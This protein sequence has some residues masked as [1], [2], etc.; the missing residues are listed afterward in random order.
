MRSPVKVV[1]F[2]LVLA[3]QPSIAWAD[4]PFRDWTKLPPNTWTL[5]HKEGPDG[6]KEFA[7]A[8][9]AEDCDR[10]YL[11]G[12]GGKLR[13]RSTYERHELESFSLA[14]AEQ[15]W[16]EALPQAK[17][18]AWADG[19]WPPF[20]LNGIDGSDGPR[21]SL[22][23]GSMQPN[24]VR[25][26]ETENVHRPS[27]I[28]TFNQACYDST[29]KRI[30]YFGGGKTLALDPGTNTWTDLAPA[31]TPIGCNSLAWGSLCYDPVN[32]EILLFGGGMAFNLDG[33]ARTWL[34]SCKKNE[35]YRPKIE[36]DEPGLRCTSAMVFEP[37]TQSMVL[38]GGNDQAA[39]LNDTWV[40]H[41][42]ER[43]WERRQPALSPPPMFVVAAATLP[44]GR[45]LICG[46]NALVGKDSDQASWAAKET[47]TYDS[48]KNAWQPIGVLK[49]PGR[50]L[51]A[52][53]STKHGVAFLVSFDP[54]ARQTFALRYDSTTVDATM[55]QTLKGAAPGT[56]RF[57]YLEQHESLASA[58]KPD[59]AAH[60]KFLANLP[61]NQFV[62]AKPPGTLVAKTWSGAVIDTARSEVIYTGGGHSGYSGNDIAIYSIAENRWSL[63]SPPRFPPFLESTG[64]AVY[65][66]SYNVRPW[67]QH[68]YLWYG[69]D[70]VSKKVIYCARP[71]IRDGETVQ[72]DPDPGK[73]FVYDS[74]KH[75]HWTWVFD[76]ATR[77]L[78]LPSFGRPFRNSWDLCLAATPRGIY[79]CT[80]DNLHQAAVQGAQ[81][82]WQSLGGALPRSRSTKYNYEW[83]PVVHDSKRDRLIHLMGGPD[84]IEVHT[85]G[86]AD[87]EWKE[88]KVAGSA[89]AGRELAYL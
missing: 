28:H 12:A 68:T 83:L 49:L 45:V 39:A 10:I 46:S 35:W 77:K 21:M 70:P 79:A 16:V 6:G 44:G 43:R 72:L 55:A 38:F 13:N 64:G 41:C 14:P 32:D 8:V 65:G 15:K 87:K 59:V 23:G 47:W 3:A 25:F 7:Q 89:V 85:R 2:V 29:R 56:K 24:V 34:Y 82:E 71:G 40:Y 58:P 31:K 5:I 67:S 48:A 1:W 78:S 42:K 86:L 54:A 22:I 33:G 20:R 57:K 17:E 61:T 36:A 60:A 74:K 11:W 18:K 37:V 50:W 27:P 26:F 52:T 80:L 53:S 76:P 63:D 66:W 9:L 19:K 75:G 81:V 88:L 30:V 73:A 62:E 84:L 51:T 69:Y 4:E